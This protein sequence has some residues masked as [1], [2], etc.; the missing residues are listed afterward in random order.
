MRKKL[1]TATPRDRG[2]PRSCS[3]VRQDGLMPIVFVHGVA[4][5]DD[6]DQPPA[7]ALSWLTRGTEWP[8]IEALLREHI[9]PR[10]N[11]LA[12]DEVAISRV[13][14]GDLG[15][16]PSEPPG[17]PSDPDDMLELGPQELGERLQ[18]ALLEELPTADWPAAIEACWSV[19]RDAGVRRSLGGLDLDGQRS[20]LRKEVRARMGR[21]SSG[22]PLSLAAVGR[23]RVRRAVGGVRRPYEAFTP[24]FV[25]DILRYMNHRGQPGA[26]GVIIER[27]ASALRAAASDV[28]PLVV[29]THSMGGQIVFD[30]LT[31]FA[32]ELGELRVDFWAC[33]ASQL[34][35]F[36]DLGVFLDPA[37]PSAGIPAERLG[38]L[39]NAWSSTDVLSFPAEGRIAGAH[40]TDFT[41]TQVASTNH[42]TYLTAP[43]FYRTLGAL[44]GAHCPL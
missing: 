5:R 43:V 26:P 2:A 27:V 35:L 21:A 9:A 15:A 30:T 36:A 7:G 23:R 22:L 24:L 41:F 4:I 32:S 40:D 19:A 11:P 1:A 6:G 28:E 42:A 37:A 38:Y 25:G 8:G 17:A 10:L 12:P 33:T 39:W 44:V 20:V 3:G 14:W 16:P 29:L 13:Y 31:A 18:S 34:G